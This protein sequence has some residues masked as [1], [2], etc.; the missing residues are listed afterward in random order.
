MNHLNKVHTEIYKVERSV[1][2]SIV[3]LVAVKLQL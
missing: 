2:F 1:A 3:F